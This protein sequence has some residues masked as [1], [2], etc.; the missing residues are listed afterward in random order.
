MTM[1][2][3]P[4][5]QHRQLVSGGQMNTSK[6][7]F[8]S[9]NNENIL[10]N[11]NLNNNKTTGNSIIDNILEIPKSLSHNSNLTGIKSVQALSRAG[12]MILTKHKAK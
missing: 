8:S 1:V 6:E 11:N 5:S 7:H 10:S 12:Q 3:T 9:A 4:I 2:E